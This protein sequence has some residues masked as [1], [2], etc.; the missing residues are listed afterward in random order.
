MEGSGPEEEEKEFTSNQGNAHSIHLSCLIE[1]VFRGVQ[2]NTYP[3]EVQKY[4]YPL[5]ALITTLS[6]K[7][8]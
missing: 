6:T 1:K 2:L 7:K 4:I 8:G 5:H 3:I